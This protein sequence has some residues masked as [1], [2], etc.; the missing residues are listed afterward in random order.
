MLCWDRQLF[1]GLSHP[2]TLATPDL[3]ANLGRIESEGGK[4]AFA[5]WA[6]VLNQAEFGVNLSRVASV[7]V[8][9]TNPF[10]GGRVQV[11]IGMFAG[12]LQVV[13][14]WVC[15]LTANRILSASEF[16]RA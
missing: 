9:L 11:K 12:F 10:V 3:D 2:L 1:G 8:G 15:P 14:I 13:T 16:S 4:D 5:V 7:A 6:S